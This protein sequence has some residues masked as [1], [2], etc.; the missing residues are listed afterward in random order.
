MMNAVLNKSISSIAWKVTGKKPYVN[1]PAIFFKVIFSDCKC[2]WDT[3]LLI[4]MYLCS[5]TPGPKAKMTTPLSSDHNFSITFQGYLLVTYSKDMFLSP[6]LLLSIQGQEVSRLKNMGLNNCSGQGKPT[7]SNL[8][9]STH[10]SLCQ[11]RNW[12]KIYCLFNLPTPN[13][14]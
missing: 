12:R 9:K 7:H 2:H 13:S 14:F 10:V 1:I 4:R 6:W 5:L 11:K 8:T 3:N